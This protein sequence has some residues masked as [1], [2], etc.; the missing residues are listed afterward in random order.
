MMT[1]AIFYLLGAYFFFTGI[2]IFASPQEFYDNTPGLAAMGPFNF[3]FIRDIS[4]VFLASG[5]AMIYGARKLLRPLLIFAAAWPCMHAIFHTQ[6]WAHRGFP[7]DDI[8]L[9]DLLAV[10]LPGM[11]A[12]AIA[13][14][15]R[16]G[17][18]TEKI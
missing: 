15:Y 11:L 13:L 16:S 9:F 4:F 18:T 14:F 6:I 3:H 12:F 1:K 8:W 2:Y 7:F 10:I 17:R 5:G